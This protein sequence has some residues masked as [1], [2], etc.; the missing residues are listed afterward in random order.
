VI[1]RA[2]AGARLPGPIIEASDGSPML[3]PEQAA[4]LLVGAVVLLVVVIWR[5]IRR[6]K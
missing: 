2:L 6:G 5:E 4:W 1:A 3:S